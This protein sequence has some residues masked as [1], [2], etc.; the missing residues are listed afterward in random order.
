MSTEVTGLRR[1][2]AVFKPLNSS[3]VSD[4]RVMHE[5]DHGGK[6]HDAEDIS[7]EEPCSES[8]YELA[9]PSTDASGQDNITIAHATTSE[10]KPPPIQSEVADSTHKLP[11]R[12]STSAPQTRFRAQ[13]RGTTSFRSARRERDNVSPSSSSWFGFD[14]SI[15]VALVS[16]IGNI[17]TGND[18]IKN[19][20]LIL[21]LIYYLHELVEV[22]WKLYRMSIPSERFHTP[23]AKDAHPIKASA[24]SEL[25][26]LELFYLV[27][28]VLSPFL[29]ATLLK[30]V[31]TS[32]SGNPNT[33]SWFS[34]SLFVLATG[35]RPWTHLSERLKD[36]SR[37]L[38]TLLEESREDTE[39]SAEYE[40]P[41]AEFDSEIS[42]LRGK[43][44]SMDK[45]LVDL[46]GSFSREWDE[47]ADAI[48]AIDTSIKRHQA[49]AFTKSQDWE[50]RLSVLET[51][52]LDLHAK[53]RKT[54][55]HSDD[56]YMRGA[57]LRAIFWDVLALPWTISA[58]AWAFAS[59]LVDK[60]AEEVNPHRRA[61]VVDKLTT[62]SRSKFR[63]PALET[64]I[65][66]DVDG[67]D[68]S[69]QNG[70]IATDSSQ[71]LVLEA[72][73][74]HDDI[75]EVGLNFAVRLCASVFWP[76]LF[77]ARMMLYFLNLPRSAL[78]AI[79]H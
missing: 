74:N 40:D 79:V 35:I 22:P 26:S 52:V 66:E 62:P 8:E 68:H 13:Q 39:K 77:T 23:P 15:I 73:Q 37:A 25:R 67:Q 64:I 49:E 33:L 38:T 43:F 58:I 32:I 2:L 51:Y 24:Y 63:A 4:L 19:I 54:R 70:F 21:L 65:E 48:D 16:P 57:R 60:F 59:R 1:R 7:P 50:A 61:P 28:T 69:P 9:S 75:V 47:L 45:R 5:D 27:L 14:L 36:R 18:H 31:A 76:L 41:K 17:L 56:S 20:L 71:T 55:I 34:T 3:P 53:D 11:P 29:G 6:D 12:M 46:N 30:Y 78:R 10:E 72:T 44:T 42:D